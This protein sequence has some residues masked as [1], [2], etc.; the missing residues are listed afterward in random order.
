MSCM[1]FVNRSY[2]ATVPLKLRPDGAIQICLLLL[3]LKYEKV[4]KHKIFCH[5]RSGYRLTE[6]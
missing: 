2:V 6:H 3:L 5:N 4:F 1:C